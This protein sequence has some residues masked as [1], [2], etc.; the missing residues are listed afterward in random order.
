MS[1]QTIAAL[2]NRLKGF[3][4]ADTSSQ[5][6]ATDSVGSPPTPSSPTATYTCRRTDPATEEL[7]T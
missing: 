7:N 3:V 2:P 5:C 1:T 6:G 4:D